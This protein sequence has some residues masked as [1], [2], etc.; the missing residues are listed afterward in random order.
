MEV[1]I[2]ISIYFELCTKGEGSVFNISILVL[3]GVQI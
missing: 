1:N 2:M 3:R